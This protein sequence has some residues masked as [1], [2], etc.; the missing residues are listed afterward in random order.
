MKVLYVCTEL[1]PFLKTGGLADVSAGLPPALRALGCDVRL[2]MPAFPALS[3]SAASTRPIAAL[4]NGQMPWG[5]PPAL[6]PADV[7]LVTLS[8]L[9]SPLYLVRSP[10]LYERPGS[11]YLGP[12]GHDWPDNALR[13][14]ALGWAAAWLGQG[15]DP[16]WSPDVIHCHDW[17]A[18]L[19]PAYVQVM[20]QA[21]RAAPATVFSIH[22][23]A[24]QGLFAESTFAQLGLPPNWFGIDGLEFYGQV[25]FMKAAIRYADRITTVS[26]SYAQEVL[27]AAHGCGLDGLLRERADLLCGILNGVD[28]QVWSPATD[29]WLAATYDADNMAPKAA[30]KNALQV[31]FGLERRPG[32]LVFGVVSRLTEQKG[33]HLLIH[34]L[35][36]LVQRG[37]QLAV[38]GQG[39]PSLERALIDAASRYPGQI[40]V[41]I[42]YSEVSAH[43]VIAGSDVVLMPSAFEPCG[44]TQLYALRYGAL[45]LVRRVGGLAD[46]VVDC[47]LENLDSG[48][49]TGFVFDV[50]STDG[51]LSALRRAFVLFQR[52]D[53]WAAVQ[54]QGMGLRFDWPGAAKRYLALFQSLR[55]DPKPRHRSPRK[56]G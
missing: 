47:T 33:L 10:D 5:A 11:P 44:L 24:Y 15:L 41:R 19:A 22:N 56:K 32:A 14:A 51:L 12:D 54:R 36:E 53:Q 6:A 28:Y 31:D 48:V 40:G 30:A 17:H 38:L 3:S 46:T 45:P 7:A 34:V 43:G 20:A 55:P 18:G 50:F 29:R 26:P 4:P 23:L 13:F 27:T 39:D 52:T 49:A 42:G 9:D 2:L 35:A 1:F 21:G 37:G 16:D 25:S 8:G